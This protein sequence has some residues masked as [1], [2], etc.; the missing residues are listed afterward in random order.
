MIVA[1]ATSDLLHVDAQFADA[2]HLAL[3]EITAAEAVLQGVFTFEQVDGEPRGSRHRFQHRALALRGCAIVLV[4][5]A[6]PSLVARLAACGVSVA[7]ARGAA[8]DDLLGEL[9]AL[10]ARDAAQ[11]GGWEAATA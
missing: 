8:I 2:R 6:G 4:S 9:S 7:T 10:L 11:A 5:A 1:F 3:Y